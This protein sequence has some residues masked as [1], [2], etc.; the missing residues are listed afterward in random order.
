MNSYNGYN[1]Y[2][3]NNY[4]NNQMQQQ[5]SYIQQGYPIQQGYSQPQNNKKKPGCLKM[6]IIG[7]VCIFV[8]LFI[9][10]IIGSFLP[11]QDNKP[12]TEQIN[13]N[14]L[15]NSEWVLDTVVDKMYND[16][17]IIVS[18]VSKI[19]FDQHLNYFNSKRRIEM[20]PYLNIKI[21][22]TKNKSNV[23]LLF[24]CLN[25][26]TNEK[27][28]TVKFGNSGPIKYNFKL[29]KDNEIDFGYIMLIE[30]SNNFIKNLQSNNNVLI[31]LSSN[32]V[33]DFDYDMNE[34]NYVET[35]FKYDTINFNY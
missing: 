34:R 31:R 35:E 8:F 30:D 13:A 9:L 12:S 33:I 6:F 29:T 4:W 23:Y 2:N 27:Y 15:I 18:L 20:T 10:G 19:G 28:V 11:E 22:I 24:S 25:D 1:G 17:T 32:M 26:L 3:Q 5:P 7:F 14:N 16:T 21:K